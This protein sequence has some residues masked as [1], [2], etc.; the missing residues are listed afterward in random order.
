MK[1]TITVRAIQGGYV[2][3]YAG[4]YGGG[5]S[6]PVLGDAE[7]ASSMLRSLIAR[8]ITTNPEGGA[9]SAPSDVLAAMEANTVDMAPGKGARLSYYASADALVAIQALREATG[10]SLSG[11][12]NALVLRGT[13]LS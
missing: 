9:Y 3:D 13:A 8:Y 6:M 4:R 2:I 1:S 11:A 5:G 7:R 12:V 10:D